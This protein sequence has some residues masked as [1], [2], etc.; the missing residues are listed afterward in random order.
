[1]PLSK[2]TN[3]SLAANTVDSDK[4]AADA[5]GTAELANNATINTYTRKK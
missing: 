1:M 5:I 2:I 3:E 4:I